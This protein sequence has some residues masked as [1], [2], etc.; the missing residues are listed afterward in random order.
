MKKAQKRYLL[1]GFI[2][3][4]LSSLGVV[5]GASA[6]LGINGS[7]NAFSI[8]IAAGV[9]GGVANGFSN[10][11]GAFVGE[12]LVKE[13]RLEEIEKAMLREGALRETEMEKDLEKEIISSGIFDGIST[14]MGSLIPVIPFF[15]GYF[16]PAY[17]YLFL[18]ASILASLI[19]FFVIGLYIGKISK[20]NLLISGL[21]LMLFAVVTVAVTT[22]IKM[23]F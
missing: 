19:L 12:K 22:I 13:I 9:G 17:G 2:D 8:V 15:I 21:K 3:G 23:I 11:L 4:V 10:I 20:E 18:Y 7:I 5:I 6:A 14:I 1:R 16:I